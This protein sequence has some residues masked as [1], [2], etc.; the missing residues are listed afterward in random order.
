MHFEPER[1][2]PVWQLPLE[3]SSCDA[4]VVNRW[5]EAGEQ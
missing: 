5:S 3:S 4:L 1:L 2:D